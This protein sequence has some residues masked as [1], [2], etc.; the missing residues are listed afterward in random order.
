TPGGDAVQDVR[1]QQ[2]AWAEQD[3][4]EEGQDDRRE[5]RERERVSAPPAD[6][7]RILGP[8]SYTCPTR[9]AGLRRLG[10]ELLAGDEVPTLD[11]SRALAPPAVEVHGHADRPEALLADHSFGRDVAAGVVAAVVE[12]LGEVVRRV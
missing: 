5:D 2:H 9:V 10:L 7:R 1:W 6:H 11:R 3:V 4:P 8:R 12:L